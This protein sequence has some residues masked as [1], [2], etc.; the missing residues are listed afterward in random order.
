MAAAC[1]Q[2]RC[3]LYILQ[4]CN[5]SVALKGFFQQI[6]PGPTKVAVIG[7]GC[8]VATEPVA[9]ISHLYNIT[10]VGSCS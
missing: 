9:A 4:Q 10:H 5:N 3:M 2:M 7:A 8:S 1:H 6:V